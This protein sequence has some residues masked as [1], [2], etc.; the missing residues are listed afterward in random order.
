ML[1]A[2]QHPRARV[3]VRGSIYEAFDTVVLRCKT[4][5]ERAEVLDGRLVASRVCARYCAAATQAST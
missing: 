1:A 5:A 4:T 2:P 3:R